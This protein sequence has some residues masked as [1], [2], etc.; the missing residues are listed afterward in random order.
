MK[1]TTKLL[2]QVLPFDDSMKIDVLSRYDG[3]SPDQKQEISELCWTSYFAL[4]K[5]E[6]AY[7]LEEAIEDV[8]MGKVPFSSHLGSDIQTKIDNTYSQKFHS[9]DEETNLTSVRE[10]LEELMTQIKSS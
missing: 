7:Q 3:L 5:S 10:N 1:I 6:W 4:K 8:A 2:L 9:I